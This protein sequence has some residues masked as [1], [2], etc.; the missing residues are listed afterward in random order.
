MGV[1]I[2]KKSR[3]NKINGTVNGLVIATSRWTEYDRR[4]KKGISE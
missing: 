3:Q 1:I 2:E 4:K